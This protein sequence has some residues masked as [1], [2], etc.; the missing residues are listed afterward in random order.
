MSL[1]RLTVSGYR[2]IESL[3]L[4]LKRVN[5]IVGPNG[6]GKT[7]LYRSLA[8]LQAAAEGRF[9]RAVGFVGGAA[10]GEEAG[11]HGYLGGVRSGGVRA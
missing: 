10:G 9:A 2:S 5:V 1:T 6:S 7:N 11:A 8:L 4:R 3:A